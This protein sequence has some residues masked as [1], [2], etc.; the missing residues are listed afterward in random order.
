VLVSATDII[1]SSTSDELAPEEYE[2]LELDVSGMTC[3]SCAARVQRTLSR[4]PGVADALVNYATGRATIELEPGTHDGER[5][6]AAV[7]KAGYHAAPV[8]PSPSEHAHELA[9]RDA[10]EQQSLL[11]RILL[12]VPLALVIGTLTYA[13]P[14]DATAQWVAAALAVPVQFWCGLPFLRSA[15]ERA[16]ARSTNMDTLI[17]LST[18]A[19]FGYSTVMLLSASSAADVGGSGMTLDYDMGATIIAALL[20]ARWCEAKARGSAGRAVRELAQLGATRARLLDHDAPDGPERLVAVEQ[21]RRGDL[22]LVRPGDKLPVDGIVI[23]GSSTLDESMLTG[24]SLPVGKRAGALVTGATLNL[25]GVLRVRATAVGADTALAQLVALVERAQA[26]KPQIQRLADEIAR[27]FVPA[28]LALAALTLLGWIIAGAGEHGIAASIHL[29]HGIDAAISVLIVACPCA[30]GLATPVALLVGSGRGASLGLLIR[31][32]EILER[33]QELDTIVFD[34][35][36][37]VTTGE[38]SLADS[39]MAP[40][41]D[42]DRVL[43]LAASA[44]ASSE[45]PVAVAVLAAARDRGLQTAR[46]QEFRATPGRGVRA[47]IGG[48]D[49]WVGRPSAQDPREQLGHAEQSGPAGRLAPVLDAWEASG[50]TAVVVERDARIV[51]ALALS[52]TVKR[53]AREAIG[54]L[55]RMGIEVELLTGDNQRAATAVAVA[56]G[57]EH[58]CAGVSPSGKLEQIARLQREG[59]RV[60]MVGDGV[61]DAGALAQADLGIAMG[62]GVGTAIEAADISVVSGDLRG[63]ARA[64]ALARETYTVVLQN[65]GWALGYNLIALPLAISGLLSPAL[66][67]VAMG[68]SSISVVANS[69]R[70]RRFGAGGRDTPVRSR[71][72][73]RASIGAAALLPVALLAVLLLIAPGT[74]SVAKDAA[75]ALGTMAGMDMSATTPAR[76]LRS[77]GGC[78]ASACP[79][80]TPGANQLSVAGELGSALA[81]VWVTPAAGNLHVR[82]ELLT[83]TIAPVSEPVSIAGASAR[84]ACGPGCWTFTLRGRPATVALSASERG[85]RFALS[86]PVSWQRGQSARARSLLEQA[87]ASMRSL[88]GV[89]VYETLTSGAFDPVEKLHYRFSAPDRMAYAMSTGGRVVAIGATL[90]SLTAG[91]SWQRGSYNGSGSFTTSSWYDWQEYDQSA[92]LLGEHDIDGQRVAE[93]EL[94]SP[95]LPVWFQLRIDV[96]SGRVSQV[97]M[98]AGGHFMSDSYSQYGVPQSIQ[99]PG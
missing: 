83:A 67:A 77:N 5:L 41:E 32:A 69:L 16:R 48:A 1:A 31:S 79:I 62:T 72:Q 24:E 58:V 85:R 96:A 45:H 42:A 73:R 18:L 63:V 23:D 47:A 82:L 70:L 61:N 27:L 7:R 90:W 68:V 98:V 4:E 80:A 55:R 17:A 34:K 57:I 59:H 22:F 25:D 95:T 35:T 51:G 37:T 92:Q 13:D 49:V 15:W 75:R 76:H 60:G 74:F 56:T 40:G 6:I 28:V 84:R 20:I 38:L 21:L 81:A 11:R 94:M 26:S 66:A 54:V 3:G 88:A 91:Q 36:G 53:E 44:E 71:G 89:R 39:W 14:H 12:A 30:L 46:A 64:L 52:D 65:L 78:T 9:Q 19:S 43:A 87:V 93:V 86:L 10:R 33:S 2:H 50:Y 8:G 99:P 29:E 97:G